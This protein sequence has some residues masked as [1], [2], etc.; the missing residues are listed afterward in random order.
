M[1][2]HSPKIV[3]FL[4]AMLEYG[5]AKQT[6]VRACIC[7]KD[8]GGLNKGIL[9]YNPLDLLKNGWKKSKE[10]L[11]NGGSLVMTPMGSNP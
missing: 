4:V 11:P 6:S 1:R 9:K 7:P 10:T 5:K 8:P 2:S 3:D